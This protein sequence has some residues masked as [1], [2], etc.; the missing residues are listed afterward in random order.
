MKR[1]CVLLAAAVTATEVVSYSFLPAAIRLF[2]MLASIAVF[3]GVWMNT[4]ET[5]RTKVMVLMVSDVSSVCL[6]EYIILIVF[7]ESHRS[8]VV[9]IYLILEQYSEDGLDF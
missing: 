8:C 7:Y 5:S 3:I 4:R 9:D 1:N 6:Y 2:F